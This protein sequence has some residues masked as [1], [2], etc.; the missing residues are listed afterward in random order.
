MFMERS[1]Y[2]NTIALLYAKRARNN[3]TKNELLEK[4]Y[5]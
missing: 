5:E 1:W 2:K 4:Y 3:G